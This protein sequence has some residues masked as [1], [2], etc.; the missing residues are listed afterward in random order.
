MIQKTYAI[1]ACALF[2]Q[3]TGWARPV[4][5]TAPGGVLGP[6]DNY[7]HVRFFSEI[8]TVDFGKGVTLPLRYEFGSHYTRQSHYIGLGFR[9]PLLESHNVLIRKDMMRCYLLCGKHLYLRQDRKDK[10]KFATLDGEWKGTLDQDTFVISRDDGWELGYRNGRVEYLKTDQGRE[11]RWKYNGD[12]AVEIFEPGGA[13]VPLRVEINA[14][15]QVTGINVN[16]HS[17]KIA[18]DKRPRVRQHNKTNLIEGFTP[19]LASWER[20]DGSKESFAFEV[21]PKTV[22]PTLLHKSFNGDTS[23]LTWEPGTGLVHSVDDWNYTVTDKTKTEGKFEPPDLRRIT[24]DGLEEFLYIQNRKGITERKSV[25]KGHIVAHVHKSPGPLF[26]K[27]RRKVK[28]LEDGTEQ[29]LYQAGYDEAGRLIRQTDSSG[30][31]THFEL[32]P[33]TGELLDQTFVRTTDEVVL[34]ALA[35]K[36]AELMQAIKDAQPE[37]YELYDKIQDLGFFYI[38]EM[39]D[40]TK[41]KELVDQIKHPKKRYGLAAQA[42]H[43]DHSLSIEEKIE[44]YKKLMEQFPEHRDQLQWVIDKTNEAINEERSKK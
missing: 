19:A 16:G 28:I 17:H 23:K 4:D 44:G 10:N 29:T 24:A 33:D 38:H 3:G 43:Y 8:G 5:L 20:P 1:V 41:A 18:L 25:E 32:D 27:M 7:G 15:G 2:I 31:I 37:S 35:E 22:L 21:E 6:I 26:G 11:I 12:V 39:K 30:L 40:P 36:E 14:G 42:L 9:I 13:T 34:N